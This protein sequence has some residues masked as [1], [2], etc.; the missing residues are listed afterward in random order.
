[1]GFL[2][3]VRN[4]LDFELMVAQNRGNVRRLL[5]SGLQIASIDETIAYLLRHNASLARLGDGEFNLIF[6]EGIHFQN[7]NPELVR[8][9]KQV[10]SSNG[11]NP[12]MMIAIPEFGD[13]RRRYTHEAGSFRRGYLAM[14]A[15]RL[16]GILN[17]K[18]PYFNAQVTRLYMD[19][20]DKSQA[21]RWY[22][23]IKKLWRGRKVVLVEGEKSRVGIGND[24]LAEA[25]SIQR[26]LCP[27]RHAFDHYDRILE[28]V[29]KV[30]KD[31]LILL[32]LGPT[33]TVLAYDLCE[34]G[35]QAVDV[36]HIDVEYCWFLSGATT[37]KTIQGK[38]V[39]ETIAGR[40]VD[41]IRDEEYEKQIIA[42]VGL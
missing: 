12:K 33:A 23:E 24:L 11:E 3:T 16:Q 40:Q 41:D 37:K 13:S 25:S 10:L 36:G 14:N 26:I 18:A 22:G 7:S 38:Y 32:A 19:W 39:A 20:K 31:S 28:Q 8:R 30:E 15:K 29:C 42:R 4:K 17:V 27:A 6:G 1:M 34:K 2:T 5:N 9:M 35:Y 21:Q